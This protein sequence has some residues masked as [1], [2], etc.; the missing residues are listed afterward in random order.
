MK[1]I[2]SK[3]LLAT[4]AMAATFSGV[5]ALCAA[6][7]GFQP[8]DEG[9]KQIV[10]PFF[11]QHCAECHVGKKPQGEFSIAKKELGT[12][13]GDPVFRGKWREI[14]NVLNSHGMPPEDKPQPSSEDV[15]AVVDWITKQAVAAEVSKREQSVVLRRLNRA[16]YRNTIRDLV[17]IDFDTSPFP[18]DPP[19]GGF[20]NNG[21]ALTMSPMQ[22]EQYLAA[23]DEILDRALVEAKQPEKIHWRFDPTPG[24][25]DANH[26]RLDD[27]NN[28]IVNG[29]NN[30][31]EGDWIA[32]RLD[33]WE[34]TIGARDFRVPTAGT[35]I[36]RARVA[37]RRPSRDD[38]VKSA[39]PFLKKGLDENIAKRPDAASY[40]QAE[41][42][43]NMKHFKTDPI[44]DYGPARL[45][46]GASLGSQPRT[47]AVFDIEGTTDAPQIV[48]F[49]VR[50]TTESAGVSLNYAYEIPFVPENQW[51][52]N[53]ETFARPTALVDW[54]EIEG[55]IY[56]AWPPS[57]HTK[58]LFDSPLKSEN[59]ND[60]VRAVLE[61][62]MSEAYRRP[63][64]KE[65]VDEKFALYVANAKGKKSFV[66]KVKVPL[67]AVLINPS[68]LYLAEAHPGNF[69]E[70]LTDHELATRLSYFL[71]SSQPDAELRQ[72][73]DAGKLTD[74]K[75]RRE[76]VDRMLADPKAD[77]LVQ[78]FAGQWLGLRQVG[79]NPPSRDLY[80][81]YDRHL[82]VSIVGESEA[83]F[84]EFLQHD[85]DVR[86]MIKSD[87]VTI[88]ERLA[89]FYG[90]PDVR[91][92][93][94]R[95]VSVPEGVSRGGIV[96]QA[97]I[98]SLTSNGT[99]TSPVK[100]GTWILKTL[101]GT[102]PGLPVANAGEIAPKVPGIDKATVR[103]RLEIHRQLQQCARCHNKIDPLG[104][105]LE[106]FNAAG[107]WRE[108][109]AFG[110][111]GRTDANDPKIDASSKMPDGT[112]IVG[113]AG[114]QQAMLK[115]DDLF[116]KSLA[117]HLTTYALG[118]ELGL[119]DQPLVDGA[120]AAMKEDGTTVRSLVKAIVA[121]DAFAAK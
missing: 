97:S 100:R 54:I 86:Q 60:Y 10:V 38:V 120:V 12:D 101:L 50:F 52:Q 24:A 20:D 26:V 115:Q 73:A 2:R 39:E 90:I 69:S 111:K 55:P 42:D 13:F 31:Y 11:R 118:R 109:E 23:A 32:I 59:L 1:P 91:G 48:E 37:N 119:A 112:K 49:P 43:Q 67:T 113:V 66:E 27:Q 114:L 5:G 94:F 87:F 4:L 14:V 57:S 72:L 46:L 45:K 29:G 3:T 16:E 53:H 9:Y 78:N 81:R 89:R 104:F 70:P 108:Y 34:R 99:R 19:A 28:P 40:F 76:Q 63:V 17:G 84:K 71:W 15:A 22:V 44:Y 103:Q 35:Y 21:R 88:N 80:P 96:T 58:I 95:R 82:E 75:T 61:R 62:F 85:L 36:V 98:L 6:E 65:E 102:D 106:N 47:I 7:R 33:G 8:D 105:A 116:L 117:T 110:Y 107:E 92:D 68:F 25:P 77:A 64:T 121:S 30:T 93:A 56:D 41:Y 79:T 74:P 83:Y 18:Q 51:I